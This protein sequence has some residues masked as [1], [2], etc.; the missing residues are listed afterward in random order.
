M[1]ILIN[2]D[3][4]AIVAKHDSAE[5]LL[6]LSWIEMP[7]VAVGV[8]ACDR[9][10]EL[11]CFSDLELK[12]MYRSLIGEV[13]FKTISFS[14][15]AL[16]TLLHD[17]ITR[18]PAADLVVSEVLEQASKISGPYTVYKYVKGSSVAKEMPEIYEPPACKVKRDETLEEHAKVVSPLARVAIAD[19]PVQPQVR[20]QRQT[21]ASKPA[22]KPTVDYQAVAA[23]PVKQPWL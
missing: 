14:T 8:C 23:L 3:K 4:M 21:Q 10:L 7:H 17:A 5:A 9:V 20:P 18:I 22:T 2:K 11:D 6:K 13:D 12:L 19:I 15:D 1:N 16:L